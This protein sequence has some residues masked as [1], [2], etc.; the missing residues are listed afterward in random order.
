MGIRIFREEDRERWD[1]FVMNT[2]NS[3][4]YHLT[5]WKNVIERSFGHKS[6]YLLAEDIENKVRGILPLVQLK[7]VLFGNFMISLPYFN[8][9]GICTDNEE[10]FIQLLKEATKIAAERKS[11]HIEL[12]HTQHI[13]NGLKVNPVGIHSYGVKTTKVSMRLE[14]PQNSEELWKS[15]SSKLRSQIKRPIKEEMYSKLGKEE[16]LDSFYTVF[17]TNMRDLGTPVYSK[18]FFKNIFKEFPESA[19]ICTIYTKEKQPVASGF[20]VGFKET[21]E[22]PWASSLRSYNHYS[23]NMLLYWSALKFACENGYK[24]FDFGRSTPGEGTYK[25]K[26]QWGAKPVQLYWHYWMRNGG[27]LPELNPK[28]PKYQL[29]IKIWQ[30][31]PVSLTRVIGP[32]I[33][34]NIP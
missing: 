4:C 24:V 19:W 15:F 11:E 1:S 9:G 26:E 12:R 31:L 18:E 30:K 13:S 8:Y 34:K 29:A 33:V 7:S 27:P 5:G 23:P 10:I 22:I 2:G 16:E 28:N 25:F 21:L 6:Y 14:L 32:R 20:I 3:S 17:S